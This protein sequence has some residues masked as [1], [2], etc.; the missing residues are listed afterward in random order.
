M[1]ISIVIVENTPV[2]APCTVRT[3][4]C[5]NRTVPEGYILGLAEIYVAEAVSAHAYI[6]NERYE[7]G[8]VSVVSPGDRRK[9]LILNGSE[10]GEGET[11]D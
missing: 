9:A 1:L 6:V 7:V 5:I 4:G 3:V 10:V 11:V 2:C 8:I